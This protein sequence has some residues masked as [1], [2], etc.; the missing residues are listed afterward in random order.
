VI[1]TRATLFGL[2]SGQL[3]WLSQRQTILAQNV[4]HADTPGYRPRD[5]DAGSFH[6]L[7]ARRA[8]GPGP[9]AL[10]RTDP[11]HQAGSPA[12]RLSLDGRIERALQDLK[13]DGNAVVLEEQMARM[14]E[15]NINYQLSSNIYR[16]Y[17]Q[18]IRT[19][20]GGGGGGG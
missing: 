5:L 15:T 7:V 3:A 11:G 6:A 19:A 18:M 2:L 20:L 8:S 14:A 9:V 13:P 10:A 16:K 4:A 12:V 1:P 17:V